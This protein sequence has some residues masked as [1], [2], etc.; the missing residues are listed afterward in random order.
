MLLVPGS[1][2]ELARES[3]HRRSTQPRIQQFVRGSDNS[4][5]MARTAD[6]ARPVAGPAGL[7]L[8]PVDRAERWTAACAAAGQPVTAFHTW[9]WLHAG[10]AMTG[11]RFVPLVLT[12]GDTDL[13]V[14]PVLI[15][16]HGPFAT[17]DCVPFPYC[18]PLVPAEVLP[19]CLDLLTR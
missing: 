13:G 18:G 17:V 1:A 3:R 6:L 14:V 8:T 16:R 19:A 5:T 4:P 15:R 2:P 11:A 7:R 9:G 10:A 12:S